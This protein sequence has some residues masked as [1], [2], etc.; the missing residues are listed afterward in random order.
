MTKFR[1]E[2]RTIFKEP[3][4]RKNADGSTSITIGFPVFEVTDYV[5]NPEHVAK[6]V[7]EMMSSSPLF[8]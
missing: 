5:T 1:A 2:G 7:A 3:V 4:E 6:V 8:D